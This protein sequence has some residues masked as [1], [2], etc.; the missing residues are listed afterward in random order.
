[1]GFYVETPVGVG[2]KTRVLQ[3]ENTQ[4]HRECWSA[5]VFFMTDVTQILNAIQQGDPSASDQLLPLVYEELRLL[6]RQRLSNEKPGQTLQATALVHEAYL[7]LV[8]NENDASWDNRGH[9][10]AAA[11]EA[12]RRI[13]VN[14]AR[15]K[16]RQKRGGEWARVELD[17]IQVAIDTPA[18]ELIALDEVLE[19]LNREDPRCAKVVKLRFFA[20][21]TLQE[22]AEMMGISTRT[23]DR[24]WAYGRAW[25]FDQ[26][27]SAGQ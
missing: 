22:T 4:S 16:S 10:F 6:A 14:R 2:D 26:F 5:I 23:A 21:L 17:Q 19:L 25:M 27:E 18:E 13:L 3:F 1:M 24:Y 9:F 15:D 11:A 8:G 7:R 12:M 20:G